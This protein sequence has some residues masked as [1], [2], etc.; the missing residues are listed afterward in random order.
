MSRSLLALDQPD[1]GGQSPPEALLEIL[2]SVSEMATSAHM[3]DLND[4]L[5][6]NNVPYTSKN[7]K[8]APIDVAL[9]VRLNYPNIFNQKH[10]LSKLSQ[11]RSFDYFLGKQTAS[12]KSIEFSDAK[13]SEFEAQIGLWCKEHNRP[14]FVRCVTQKQSN[15]KTWFIIVHGEPLRREAKISKNEHPTSVYYYP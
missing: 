15:N 8:Y 12:Q 2:H 14:A 9:H 1:V 3:D 4:E 5:T 13:K 11:K 6:S 7:K 10:M